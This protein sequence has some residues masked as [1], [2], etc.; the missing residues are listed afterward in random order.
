VL[1]QNVEE[2]KDVEF[3]A[4]EEVAEEQSLEFPTV[5]QLM[6]EVNKLNKAIQ[7]TP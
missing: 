6:D 1:D 5:E 7:E 4:I 2:E 3:V